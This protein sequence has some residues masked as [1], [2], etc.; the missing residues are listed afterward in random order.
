MK[1]STSPNPSLE[2]I[3]IN[4]L[5]EAI[6]QQY[7]YDFR[8][9]SQASI[10]RRVYQYLKKRELPTISHLIP[11]LL[12]DPAMLTDFVADLSVTVTEMF[13]DPGFYLSLRK[14]VIPFLKTFPFIN[15]WHAGCATGEEVY[16]MAILLQEEGLS[17]RTHIYATDIN[18]QALQTAQNRIYP[19]SKMRA[20]SSNYIEAGGKL[21]LSDYYY[22]EYDAA[23]LS[24]TL[25]KNITFATHNLAT[26]AVFGNMQMVFCRNVLIYFNKTL[27]NQVLTLFRDSL[28]YQGFLCLGL[29]ESLQ[30]TAV[31]DKFVPVSAHE[32]IFQYKP[33]P[34]NL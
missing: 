29:K 13:R 19:L 1:Q 11:L 17:D 20:Y 15:I 34:D 5:L 27:Q 18:E 10:T 32:R 25:Q 26:D 33:Q 14:K 31:R 6:F 30:F 24:E 12:H 2:T 23:I 3:E 22:A 9:Y 21:S 16:S 8:N 4:L 7:G 28:Q